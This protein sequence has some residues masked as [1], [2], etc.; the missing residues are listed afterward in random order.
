MESLKG[1]DH[2]DDFA[3]YGKIILKCVLRKWFGRVW[4][5]FMLLIIGARD[6]FL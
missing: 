3:L 1:R 2:P 4:T 6:R 5:V